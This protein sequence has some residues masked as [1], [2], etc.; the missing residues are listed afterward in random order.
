MSRRIVRRHS[1]SRWRVRFLTTTS[2]LRHAPPSSRLFVSRCESAPK[3]T[4]VPEAIRVAAM[5]CD[6]LRPGIMRGAHWRMVR[7]SVENSMPW[8][9]GWSLSASYRLRRYS[10]FFSPHTKLMCG[11]ALIKDS[12]SGSAP[13]PTRYDQNCRDTWNCSFTLTA[14]E[15][16]IDPSARSGV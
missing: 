14:L 8:K 7:A 3:S 2:G 1:P 4:S 16:S 10:T 9:S 13:L 5:G 15:I 12:G 11:V 6:L